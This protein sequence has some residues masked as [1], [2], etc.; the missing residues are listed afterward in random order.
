M[1]KPDSWIKE[2][3]IITTC[4]ELEFKIEERLK[5]LREETKLERFIESE[6]QSKRICDKSQRHSS[7]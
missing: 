7:K 1:T 3:I 5:G 6:G 2:T 4:S